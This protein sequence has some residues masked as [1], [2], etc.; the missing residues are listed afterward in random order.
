[1]NNRMPALAFFVALL[2][3]S[4]AFAQNTGREGSLTHEPQDYSELNKAPARARSRMNPFQN[5]PDAVASG[6]ILFEDHCTECHGTAGVGGKKA[7]DLHGPEVQNATAGALFWL[8]TNGVAWKGMPVWSKLPEAQRWQL[9]RYL[10]SLGV[11]DA[12][13]A[14]KKP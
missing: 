1:M 7:P 13:R 11:K 10:Q 12:S 2:G 6:R 3:A 8:L 4:F 14:D 9:V 5:D